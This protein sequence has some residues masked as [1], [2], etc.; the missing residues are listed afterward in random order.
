MPLL[1]KEQILAAEDLDFEEVEIKEWGGKVRLRCMTGTE[2]DA[3]ESA[4]YKIKGD[5]VEANRENFRSELLSRVLCNK[6][7]KLLFNPREVKALGGKSGRVIDR[8]FD[9]AQ[10]INGIGQSDIEEMTK[11]SESEA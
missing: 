8:L 9:I 6:D 4:I 5:K 2:R 10:K 7:N 11:N 1:T 3:F